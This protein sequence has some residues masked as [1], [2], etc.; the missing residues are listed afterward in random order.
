MKHHHLLFTL[1]LAFASLAAWAQPT[2][3]RPEQWATEEAEDNPA[4][5]LGFTNTYFN[6]YY[7]KR[8]YEQTDQA[9]EFGAAIYLSPQILA[10]YR[11]AQIK[12][13]HFALWEEVGE[14]YTV[15]VAREL[16]SAGHPTQ[17]IS[18]NTVTRGNFHEGWNAVSID[19]VTITGNEG[20]YI[21][22][23]SAVSAKEAMHGNYTLDHTKGQFEPQGN[24]FM[25]AQGRWY[26]I[27]TNVNLN[28]MIRGYADGDNLPTSDIGLS[29]VDGPDIIWQ[30]RPTT[31][32]VTMTNYG[33]EHVMDV[34]VELLSDGQ[35]YDKKHFASV[36]LDHNDRI[37]IPLSGISFPDEGNHSFTLRVTKVN[38]NDDTDPSDNEHSLDLFAVPEG[39]EPY[40]RNILFEEMTSELDFLAP[41]ADYVFNA[42]VQERKEALGREDVIWVKHHI[43][44]V[45]KRKNGD[46]WDTYAT[47]YDPEYI[48]LYEGYP[49]PGCDFVPAVVADRNIFNGMEEKAGVAY[50]VADELALGGLFTLCQQIPAYIAVTP[51]VDYDPA[52]RRLAIDVDAEA[53]ISEMIRQSDLHLTVYVV[54]DALVSHLQRS[55]ADSEEFMLPDGTFIQNGVIRAYPTGVWGEEVS[56]EN[57]GFHRHYELTLDSSWEP[58][59]MRVVAFVHN[60]DV[61]AQ[62]G[63]NVVYNAGQ[64]FI[65]DPTAIEQVEAAPRETDAASAYYDLQGRRIMTNGQAQRPTHGM[66]IRKGRI[67]VIR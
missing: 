12:S 2:P 16:G 48:R 9:H 5:R 51:K 17:P 8:F 6:T 60:Y 44:G 33:V 18:R 63:N 10:K 46:P 67:E 45:G 15:F 50:F 37:T 32:N 23:I 7:T 49:T 41:K 19:P 54:E 65:S 38:G 24:W 22:W 21:G 57:L 55:N 35:V 34:D 11:G 20:L 47:K 29:N 4:V 36:D 66:Y 64:A 61:N 1:L 28:L 62:T 43:D 59:N 40:E 27:G 30:N 3:D 25:D 26:A 13:V 53:R 39:I 56:I 42:A 52:T 58:K 31:Y 14:H